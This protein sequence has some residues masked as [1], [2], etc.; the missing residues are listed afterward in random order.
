MCLVL[1][2][3]DDVARWMETYGLVISTL[4]L[5]F[6]TTALTWATMVMAQ[7]MRRE[8]E[9]KS[10]PVVAPLGTATSINNP[11][12]ITIT[13]KIANI[14]HC[15]AFVEKVDLVVSLK[16]MGK[17]TLSLKSGLALPFILLSGDSV[18]AIF[19]V[20]ATIAI[21]LGGVSSSEVD[22]FRVIDATVHIQSVG[23]SRSV[24]DKS[25]QIVGT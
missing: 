17:R 8:F 2:S 3:G 19:L 9:L 16:R 14:G 23:P 24:A 22:L 1:A 6:A 20:P 5:V 4:A 25:W 11:N 13:Q 15:T 12:G 7:W 18:D 10:I 21:D